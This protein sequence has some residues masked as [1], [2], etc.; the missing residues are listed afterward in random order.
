MKKLIKKE[1]AMKKRKDK[2]NFEGRSVRGIKGIALFQIFLM[3]SLT[4][5]VSVM[6]RPS[7]DAAFWSGWFNTQSWKEVGQTLFG[8]DTGI[9]T[10]TQLQEQFAGKATVTDLGGGL[11]SVQPI[12][13]SNMFI[14]GPSGITSAPATIV[15]SIPTPAVAPVATLPAPVA[16]TAQIS[17]SISQGTGS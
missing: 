10:A 16:P 2:I 13:S 8:E 7:G 9:P 1:E 12:G 4:F 17:G 3:I 6:I 5:A 15:S 11:S 14:A